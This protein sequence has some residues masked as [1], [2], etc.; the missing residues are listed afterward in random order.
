ML[1]KY[2]KRVLITGTTS[3]LGQA[4]HRHYASRGIEVIEVNRR[5]VTTEEEIPVKHSEVMDIT[6]PGEVYS[7]LHRLQRNG[8]LPDL[9]ILNAGTNLPDNLHHFEYANFSKVMNTNLYGVLTFVSAIQRLGLD[10]RTIATI[11]S[12][13]NIIPNP[14]HVGYHVSKWAL[15]RSFEL[16]AQKDSENSYKTVVLGPVRTKIQSHYPAA[17]GMQKLV[18]DRL[19][20]DADE[21]AQA[22]ATFFSTSKQTLH[23]P[24]A[25]SMFYSFMSGLLLL[26]PFLY[27][28]TQTHAL[29]RFGESNT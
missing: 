14:A 15:K 20:V 23:Y 9:F 8:L 5:A 12:V 28:G 3:G 18:L 22:C 1:K 29:P 4:L 11:S 24:L 10:S 7:F 17:V 6:N 25:S 13:T 26:F 21:S 16:L 27:R 2:F 19:I